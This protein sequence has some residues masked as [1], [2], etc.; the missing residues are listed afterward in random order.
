MG[1]VAAYVCIQFVNEAGNDIPFTYNG[2][3]YDHYV[4]V[5]VDASGDYIHNGSYTLSSTTNM[6]VSIRVTCLD[7]NVPTNRPFQLVV[8]EDYL[9]PLVLALG[10]TPRTVEVKCDLGRLIVCSTFLPPPKYDF[11]C[12]VLSL[13]KIL[14]QAKTENIFHSSMNNLRSRPYWQTRTSICPE[15]GVQYQVALYYY[16]KNYDFPIVTYSSV[17]TY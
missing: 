7:T 3:T 16:T 17:Y 14:P 1:R 13:F 10:S 9:R 8:D 15:K 2:T 4:D 6:G 5:N 11:A 12:A